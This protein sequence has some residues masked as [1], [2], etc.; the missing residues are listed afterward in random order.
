MEVMTVVFLCEL[1]GYQVKS[2]RQKPAFK[3]YSNFKVQ[4]NV[5]SL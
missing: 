1:A 4:K 3:M 5:H 2:S